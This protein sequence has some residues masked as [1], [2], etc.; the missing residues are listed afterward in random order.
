MKNLVPVM[1]LTSLFLISSSWL[2]RAEMV[3][4]Q[5]AQVYPEGLDISKLK[6]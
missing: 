1:V 4:F 2:V 5:D 3:D 6:A